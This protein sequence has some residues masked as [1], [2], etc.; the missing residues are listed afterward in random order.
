LTN[1]QQLFSEYYIESLNATQSAIQAGYSEK[2]AH[3]IGCELLKNIK[4]KSYIDLRLNERKQK[5]IMS[6]DEVLEFLTSVA[7][8]EIVETI[9][10]GV[11]GGVQILKDNSPSM[12]DRVKAAELLGKRHAIFT[13]R[14]SVDVDGDV[15]I[16]IVDDI[17]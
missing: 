9:P 7:K 4:V 17:D 1:K 6:A 16:K 12:K 15:S 3:V 11:G 14:K 13:D 10:I 8:G 5:A 2:T